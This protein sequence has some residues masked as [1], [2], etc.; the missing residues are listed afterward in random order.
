LSDHATRHVHRLARPDHRHSIDAALVLGAGW[1]LGAFFS[2]VLAELP[3][4]SWPF[5]HWGLTTVFTLAV[6]AGLLVLKKKSAS[7]PYMVFYVL[8]IYVFQP[9]PNPLQAG[10]LLAGT[11]SLFLLLRA[12][13]LRL[14]KDRW[15][16]LLLFAVSMAT[17]LATLTPAV[18]TRDGYELQ[19]ISATLGFAHPTGYPLFPILGRL[20]LLIFPVG[21]IAWRINVLCALLAAL[22]VPL[23]YG[24]AKRVLGHRSFAA[25]GALSLAFSN[26]LW[27]QAVRPEKY[28]LNAFFVALTLYI[29]FGTT[30]PEARSPHPHLRWLAWVYGL[31]LGHH[32][33][34]L[35]L[36]PALGI[37]ILW[38]DPGLLKRPRE[39]LS[40]LGIA[41]VPL[42]VYLYIPWRAAVQGWVMTV[43]EFVHYVSGAAY[44][45][46]VR[47]MDWAAPER[48]L[49]FW[50]FLL[51]QF[52][53]VGIAL[54]VIGMIGLALRRRW[55]F[56]GCTAL[57]YATY[58][59]WGTVWY[60][61]Y[62][63]VNSFIPN[64]AIFAVWIASGALTIWQTFCTHCRPVQVRAAAAPVF[65]SLI[66][67]LP[68]WMIWTNGPQ[69]DARDEW[70]LTAWGAYAIEQDIA[71][72]A[73][74]LADREKYPP[75]DYFA[76][77]ERRRP[78]L[79][80]VI[81]GDER[82]YL[83]RLTWDLAQDK[84][85]YLARFLPGLEGPYHLRS[86]GPL[87]H[88]GTAPLSPDSTSHP[89]VTEFGE[90]IQ[91]LKHT[92]EEAQPLHGG[93][94]LHVT[95]YWYAVSPVPGN[96]QVNLRLVSDD[97]Q[98][99]WAASDHPVSGMYPTAAWKPG[100]VIPDWYE[101]PIGETVPPG[102]YQLEVGLF[103]PFS[104][105]GL[106]LEKGTTWLP[107]RSITILPG[108][109]ADIPRRL[110]AIQPEQWQL[111]GYD[112]PR[113]APPGGRAWL[114]LYWQA[115]APMAD[116]EVG[117]RLIGPGGAQPWTWTV[118]GS[119]EY[120]SSR[121]VP[122]ETVVTQHV[123]AM[124]R[125]KGESTVQ[126]AVRQA[127]RPTE[128]E[129]FYPRWLAK[130]TTML[131]FALTVAGREPTAPGTVNFDDRILL[132]ETEWRDRTLSPGTPLEL[133]VLWGCLQAMD[134][135]YTLF[136]QLLGPD[137][138]LKGQVD[139]WPQEGTHPTSAW[140]E[141]ETI[142]DHY[143][144][145]LADDAPP[146]RYQVAIGWYLLETMQRLPVLDNEGEAVDDR[147]LVPGLTVAQ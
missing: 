76:R 46:A 10:V 96:Y 86:V 143:T 29:A 129:R 88:V 104:T 133:G 55:R 27:T 98:E 53:H 64:H 82:A 138:T 128:K 31:S 120:P 1:V 110:R 23:V 73:T 126:L 36:A 142:E 84:A 65:W 94:S 121:W 99:W 103:P 35:M 20:W 124:P 8:L 71:P 77:I 97:G 123:L 91:L 4:V 58:Y 37:Y 12:P 48:F 11:L 33:T 62:N 69:V 111:L 79:D 66:A 28:T 116:I 115:L 25:L 3:W 80:V 24:T 122:G 83:D 106:V 21:S 26:T 59:G 107:L 75:L 87:V 14:P 34:M 56:L 61:Y 74:V 49:M 39:W 6:G 146:G 119:G 112:L 127:S 92:I 85:V 60:A 32:R 50:R 95:L 44:S 7:A 81:L 70:N 52:G 105:E 30:D 125:E 17:Y 144:I 136:V 113:Q 15:I 18:G 38:R 118:P 132:L 137:G 89:A 117:T 41:L 145:P 47:L 135:D 101:I 22:C 9:A 147:M 100:E 140:H 51:A 93:D 108:G 16:A 13:R 2:R 139:V 90:H 45:P 78:D 68:M 141:G 19:A 5:Y 63:D 67:L 42:L 43:P 72:N 134:A 131:S 54:G 114:T 109:K 57:A 102:T 130:R 40:A